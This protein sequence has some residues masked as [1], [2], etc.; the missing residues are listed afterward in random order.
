M[1]PGMGRHAY[2]KPRATR[3]VPEG[4]WAVVDLFLPGD[5]VDLFYGDFPTKERALRRANAVAKKLATFL[6]RIY[7]SGD[8]PYESLDLFKA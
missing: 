3:G 1:V 7:A 6:G 2:V 8:S 5:A 4:W